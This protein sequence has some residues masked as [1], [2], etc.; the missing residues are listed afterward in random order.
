MAMQGF[1][2]SHISQS[3]IPSLHLQLSAKTKNFKSKLQVMLM[4]YDLTT[5]LHV[6]LEYLSLS[7]RFLV[8]T[9]LLVHN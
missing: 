7:Y 3:F 8:A 1:K 5:S 9:M 2:Y 6:R 4:L